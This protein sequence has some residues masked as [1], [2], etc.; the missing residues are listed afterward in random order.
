MLKHALQ[1]IVSKGPHY[2]TMVIITL[3]VV[4]CMEFGRA[5]PKEIATVD[6]TGLTKSYVEELQ[7]KK[8]SQEE[9]KRLIVRYATELESAIQTFANE[10]QLVL[11]PKEA[12]IAGSQDYTDDIKERLAK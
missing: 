11:M 10:N 6:I 9:V 2:L 4:L 5:K 7:A 12:I 3:V 8:L 1:L